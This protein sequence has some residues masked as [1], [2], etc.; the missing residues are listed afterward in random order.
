MNQQ[1]NVAG[2]R[3][4]VGLVDRLLGSDT[5]MSGLPVFLRGRSRG[6]AWLFAGIAASGCATNPATGGSQHMLISEAQEIEMGREADG[7]V[8]ASIGLYDDPIW[9]R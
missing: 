7:A 6:L 2:F 9:Q 5:H 4:K 8:V 1:S 3:E